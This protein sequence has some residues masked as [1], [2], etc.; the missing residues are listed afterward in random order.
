V[1]RSFT[2]P[3]RRRAVFLLAL[4]MCAPGPLPAADSPPQPRREF[5]GVWIASVANINWPSKPGLPVAQQQS[6]LRAM[7]DRAVELKLNA[8]ILQVRPSAEALYESKLEPWSEYLTGVMGR[9]PEPRYDPLAFAVDEAHQR[10]LELHAW[11]NPFRARHSSGK[12][13]VSPDHLS[14]RRPELV[15]RYGRDLWFDPGEPAARDH[16]LAVIYDVLRRYDIDGVHIDDYFYPYPEKDAQGKSAPFP[17]DASWKRYQ[18]SG[19]KLDRSDW[20]RDNVNRFVEQLYAGVKERKPWVKFG[21]SP[22]GIWRPGHPPP[23]KG[24]DAYEALYADA[25]LWLQ[26]GWC[27]YFAPQLYW[28]VDAPGQSYPVL[29]Q[30]WAEQNPQGRHL[31]PGNHAANAATG[32]WKPEELLRQVELTR[33]QRG[34]SGNIWLNMKSLMPGSPVGTVLARQAYAEPALVPA[35]PWLGKRPPA[36]PRVEW[37]PDGDGGTF[38]W[39]AG[40]DTPVARWLLQQ[41]SPGGWQTFILPAATTQHTIS[42][43]AAKVD[44]VAIRAVDRSGNLGP[45][46]VLPVTGISTARVESSFS[47]P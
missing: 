32:K 46:V 30:W 9:A 8:V 47:P 5:R 7:L 16:A 23:V 22:F 44:S 15:R 10:G 13:A 25:R 38:V 41:H 19:G 27:D 20:R 17:D 2:A 6:E 31:W 18:A 28:T 39:R 4:L 42:P 34:A 43:G 40:D 11:F 29:L 24:L 37:R 36:Q 21:I 35:S 3:A 26:K 33:K 1:R 45:P 12:S 14:V